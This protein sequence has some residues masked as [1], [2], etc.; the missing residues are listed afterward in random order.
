MNAPRVLVVGAGPAGVRA[1]ELLAANGMHV[2]V[3][4]EALRAG[5]QIYRRAPDGFTRPHETLYGFEAA[6]AQ[7]LHDAFDRLERVIDYRPETL[8]WNVSRGV[9]HSH[10]ETSA[11]GGYGE[12]PYDALV[13]ASG[14]HDRVVPFAGWTMPGVYTLGGAQVA[15]KYQGCAVG[16]RVLF[17]GS[18]P[19][20][21]LVAYQ[22]A[23]AGA[24]VAGVLDS[25]R[26]GDKLR[27]L[28]GLPA[29]AAALAKGLFYMAALRARGIVIEHGV[30]PV[31]ALGHGGRLAGLRILDARGG[32]R[33]IA[34]D[35]IATGYGLTPDTRLADLAGCEFRYEPDSRTWLP[36]TDDDGRATAAGVYLAGDGA[37]IAGAD[38][39]EIRGALAAYA[40]IADRGGSV[41]MARVADLRRRLARARRF[42]T[43]LAKGFPFPHEFAAAIGDET[44][45]CRC[46]S[47]SAGEFRAA[48][49]DLGAGEMNR[50]KAFSRVGMGRCQG[51]V[52]GAAATEVIAAALNVDPEAV[53]RAR[54]QAPVKPIPMVAK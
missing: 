20:L 28:K 30:L 51:R 41:P 2:I 45:L 27:A 13:I 4:D 44:I 5:G 25:A 7:A 47:I 33:E 52:C 18:G 17:C 46:E 26:F 11:A 53:G 40:V 23:R 8:I 49:S 37:G 54:G 24:V 31:E 36:V 29:G 19:L 42:A 12:I 22:Y 1:A 35:A 34:C 3:A 43:A 38:A 10:G 16:R 48:I 21:Y 32:V 15:L 6:K 14:A 39:A 9:A 50:A